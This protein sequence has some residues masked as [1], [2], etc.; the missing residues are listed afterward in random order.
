[1]DISEAPTRYFIEMM[2]KYCENPLHMEKLK[3]MCS[4]TPEGLDQYYKY[5]KREKR[6]PYEI[7]N[8]F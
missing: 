3:E 2:L 1:L 8:D 4:N 5:V 7:L 6:N